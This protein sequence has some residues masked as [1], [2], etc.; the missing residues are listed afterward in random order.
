MRGIADK[1]DAI[2]VPRR[3]A[4]G[5]INVCFNDGRCVGQKRFDRLMPSPIAFQQLLTQ[6]LIRNYCQLRAR[7][8]SVLGKVAPPHPPLFILPD[9]A[10]AELPARPT[11]KFRLLRSAA[12]A[13]TTKEGVTKP[14]TPSV[15]AGKIGSNGC[16]IAGHSSR[17]SNEAISLG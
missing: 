10:I 7:Q 12:S 14:P 9:V 4:W 17:R 8:L 13:F 1:N 2:L 6:L 5:L 3:E 16:G 15:V 11:V